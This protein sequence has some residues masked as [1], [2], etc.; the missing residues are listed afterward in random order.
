MGEEVV[1]ELVVGRHVA[2][3]GVAFCW[4]RLNGLAVQVALL[5]GW[6]SDADL[7]IFV[8]WV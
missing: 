4:A 7:C 3:F 2:V 8:V 5:V 6:T 1:D